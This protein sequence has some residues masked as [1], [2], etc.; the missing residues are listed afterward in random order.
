MYIFSFNPFILLFWNVSEWKVL[1]L[2]GLL[3]GFNLSIRPKINV[4]SDD[5]KIRRHKLCG[6][7]CKQ[8]RVFVKTGDK[9]IFC[10]SQF[11][12][13][14]A[15]TPPSSVLLHCSRQPVTVMPLKTG[16]DEKVCSIDHTG[17][18]VAFLPLSHTHTM[19]WV[20]VSIH[21]RLW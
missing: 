17:G 12:S 6:K 2:F 13:G 3:N 20:W 18:E 7:S 9:K 8:Q 1:I 11:L 21:P 16:K 5:S 14:H 15:S 19:Y 4:P 10:P